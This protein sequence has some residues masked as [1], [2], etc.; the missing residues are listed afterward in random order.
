MTNQNLVCDH[1]GDSFKGN[2]DI[3]P[4]FCCHGCET[5]YTLLNESNLEQFYDI[6]EEAYCFDKPLSLKN[7]KETDH[8]HLDHPSVKERLDSRTE[9]TFFVE[10]VHC[11]ACMWLMEKLPLLLED[12]SSAE[13]N[14]SQSLLHLTIS[15]QAQLSLIAKTLDNLGYPAHLIMN[16]DEK[17]MLKKKDFRQQLLRIG[18]AG[19]CM[20]NHMIMALALYL[21]LTGPL[22]TYFHWFSLGLSLPVVFYSAT[23]FYKSVFLGFKTKQVSIDLPIAIAIFVAWLVSIF[24]IWAG[25]DHIYFDT[26]SMLVFLLL[27]SRTLLSQSTRN[28]SGPLSMLSL[29]VP[30]GVTKWD[31]KT[32]TDRF[33]PLEEV[34]KDDELIF[35]PGDTFSVDG[36]ITKGES[37]CDESSLTGEFLPKK[38]KQGSNVYAGTI[39]IQGKVHVKTTATG[40]NS[41][42]GNI[43][44][45]LGT[46]SKKG[47]VKRADI[48]AKW[49]VYSILSITTIHFIIWLF[50][51]LET[52]FNRS[53]SIIIIS[54][55]CALALAT[56][57]TVSLALKRATEMGILIKDSSIFEHIHKI[58]NI[59]LDK[60]GTLTIGK[61]SVEK[62]IF[63]DTTESTQELQQILYSLESKSNHPIAKAITEYLSGN[64]LLH[65]ENFEEEVGVGVKGTINGISYSVA[66]DKQSNQSTKTSVCLFRNQV[67]VIKIILMDKLRDEAQILI[68]GFHSRSLNI[69]LLSGDQKT[70]TT[71]YGEQLGISK[72]T[73]HGELL[74]DEKC[75]QIKKVNHSLMIGDGANDV[76]ALSTA[77]VGIAVQGSMEVSLQASDAYLLGT[78]LTNILSLIDLS[79]LTVQT[80]I[81]NF[82][83]S[84]G[85][86]LI[87]ITLAL[88][89]YVTPLV[90]AIFMPLS[91]LTV[92]LIAIIR[93]RINNTYK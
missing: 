78:N 36:T 30:S 34:K 57:L 64:I 9:V 20:G 91:A 89:G 8:R 46:L 1:C 74:P 54:C 29:L 88:L 16:D 7:L 83:V 59:F 37:T 10:G 4:Y 3:M 65:I 26:I 93:L 24:N 43:I 22:A 15:E 79:H 21:G 31:Q 6:K 90:S 48:I 70:V 11:V 55:P 68:N 17:Q 14:L 60:T 5:V 49:F 52:A 92:Y 12:V 71:Y 86:N 84:L 73:I 47:I 75:E 69:T 80:M 61:F 39:N 2:P 13:L 38:I 44:K 53:L 67:T 32:E 76:L 81:I 28:L 82:S 85:Y 23:P 41:R 62:L 51:S 50:F 66:Q 56:P 33:I 19:A 87:G 40:E 27:S 58:K 42:L 72:E 25:M 63:L 18:I 35:Q 45:T 77:D